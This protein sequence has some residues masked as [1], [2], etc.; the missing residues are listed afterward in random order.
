[1]PSKTSKSKPSKNK[2][3]DK[4]T[5]GDWTEL[6]WLWGRSPESKK[7][8]SGEANMLAK[9][10]GDWASA[11]FWDRELEQRKPLFAL[12]NAQYEYLCGKLDELRGLV[13]LEDCA[14]LSAKDKERIKG[15]RLFLR[16]LSK[17]PH[18]MDSTVWA[19]IA[20]LEDSETMLQWLRDNLQ[21]AW[22]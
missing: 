19:V 20:E 15:C 17:S 16:K 22:S 12:E 21:V 11:S 18:S 7:W 14:P 8:P 1:M 13:Q 6:L 3:S 10:R 5:G 2:P 9:D 4:I